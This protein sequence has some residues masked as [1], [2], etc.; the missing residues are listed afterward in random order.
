MRYV[1][2]VILKK[3][4]IVV[5]DRGNGEESPRIRKMFTSTRDRTKSISVCAAS[6]YSRANAPATL[7]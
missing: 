5:F 2:N 7:S 4:E 6:Q 1:A 3:D